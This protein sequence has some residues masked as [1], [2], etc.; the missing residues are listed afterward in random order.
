M[1]ACIGLE[2]V[3]VCRLVKYMFSAMRAFPSIALCAA[4]AVVSVAVG[5]RGI[6]LFCCLAVTHDECIHVLE[7]CVHHLFI[8][9][10]HQLKL[11]LMLLLEKGEHHCHGFAFFLCC[12]KL[13]RGKDSILET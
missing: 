3:T 11:R 10:R 1:L 4:G 8:G 7:H 13:L 2:L 9:C 6:F 12:C 5:G